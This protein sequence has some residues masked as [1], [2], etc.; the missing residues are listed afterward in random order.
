VAQ[1]LTDRLVG[2]RRDEG[3]PGNPA[4]WAETLGVPIERL[5]RLLVVEDALLACFARWRR[6]AHSSSD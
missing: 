6:E 3:V 4:K 1:W 5:G 2:W